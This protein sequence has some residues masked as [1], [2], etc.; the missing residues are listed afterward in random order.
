[1]LILTAGMKPIG[2]DHDSVMY[3]HELLK[4]FN[5][6]N[7]LSKELS[8]WIFQQLNLHLF[9]GVPMPFF[10]A[11]AFI[12]ILIKKYSIS[13]LST[14]PILSFFTYICFFFIMQDMTQ[15]RAGVATGLVFWS[16]RS[17]L[18]ENRKFFILK[19]ALATLFHYSAIVFFLLYFIKPKFSVSDAFLYTALP[20]LGVLALKFELLNLIILNVYMYL[21]D[22][23][24]YKVNIY[25]NM[26]NDGQLNTVNPINIGNSLLLLFL[27]FTISS[28]IQRKSLNVSCDVLTEDMKVIILS[29]K[30]LSIG[31][32]ILFSCSFVEVFAY[33][34]ANYLFFSSLILIIPYVFIRFR[35]KVVGMLSFT[36]YAIYNLYSTLQLLDVM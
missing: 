34:I 8:F 30:W 18:N 10:M 4:S 9:G 23:L 16:M 20:I 33:R 29:V 7:L 25:L 31:F 2:L 27:F 13:E 26:F 12:S 14:T 3:Q 36:M 19:I 28:I 24:Y 5:E 6:I 32:F 22:F 15:I 35:P 21:P 1:V 11:Y 17:V